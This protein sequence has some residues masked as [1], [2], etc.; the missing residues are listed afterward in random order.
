MHAD[1]DAVT[2]CAVLGEQHA[3]GAA[4]LPSASSFVA[5][6]T[7]NAIAEYLVAE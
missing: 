7:R 5:S 2:L 6:R 4:N 1:N 3:N